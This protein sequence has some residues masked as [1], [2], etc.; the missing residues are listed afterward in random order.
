MRNFLVYL[1]IILIG[2]GVYWGF[3]KYQQVVQENEREKKFEQGFPSSAANDPPTPGIEKRRGSISGKIGYPSEGIPE[4]TIYAIDTFDENKFFYVETG[5]NQTEFTIPD[6]DP[7]SYYV[8][9]YSKTFDTRG[10][11]TNAVPCGLSVDCTDHTMIDVKVETGE[12]VSGVDVTDWYAPE[13]AFP[14]QPVIQ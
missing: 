12:K 11:Y 13:G 8:V 3:N 7:G 10:S 6:V 9:A 5:V 4:L 14:N 1:A 2:M